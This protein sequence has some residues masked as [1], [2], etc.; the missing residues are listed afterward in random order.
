MRI[1][2]WPVLIAAVEM[3]IRDPKLYDQAVWARVTECG[4]VRCIAGWIAHFGGWVDDA[5]LTSIHS[6]DVYTVSNSAHRN[7]VIEHAAL[8]SLDLDP[9][10][11]GEVRPVDFGTWMDGATFSGE[12]EMLAYRLFG[13]GRHFWEIL[14]TVRDLAE[15]DGVTLP[16][17]IVSEMRKRGIPA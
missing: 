2:N 11:Y 14:E 8:L 9:E 6:V 5:P 15:A 4:T 16:D 13:G 3:A 12:V 10:Y 17:V 7:C 1:G